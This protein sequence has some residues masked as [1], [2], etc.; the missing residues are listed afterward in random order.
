MNEVLIA[1]QYPGRREVKAPCDVF[2]KPRFRY[3]YFVFASW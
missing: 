2:S 3:N 1:T